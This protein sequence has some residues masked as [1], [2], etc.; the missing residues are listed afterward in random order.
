[1]DEREELLREGDRLRRDWEEY[2]RGFLDRVELTEE[3]KATVFG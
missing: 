2:L 1:M 3:G